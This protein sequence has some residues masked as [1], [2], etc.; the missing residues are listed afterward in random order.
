LAEQVTDLPRL[1]LMDEALQRFRERRSAVHGERGISGSGYWPEMVSE[2]LCLI[3]PLVGRQKVG[4]VRHLIGG[5]EGRDV[6][7]W[8][9]E[10]LRGMGLHE[11][12]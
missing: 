8:R 12:A 3:T 10:D 7:R 9:C 1:R 5:P 4:A 2:G 6:R 11:G